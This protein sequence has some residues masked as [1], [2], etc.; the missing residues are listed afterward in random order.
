MLSTNKYAY[1][2]NFIPNGYATLNSKGVIVESNPMFAELLGM[3]YGTLPEGRFSSFLGREQ[4]GV[5]EAYCKS[6]A[7]SEV[8]LTCE[9][10]L[11]K[12]GGDKF[13]VML[14]GYR[15][16]VARNDYKIQVLISEIVMHKYVKEDMLIGEDEKRS[17]RVRN[18]QDNI[19]S[20]T[21]TLHDNASYEHA[22]SNDGHELIGIRALSHSLLLSQEKK[23]EKMTLTLRDD[24]GQAVA[25]LQMYNVGNMN[26]CLRDECSKARKGMRE[27][28]AVVEKLM[29]NIQGM[30]QDN[31]LADLGL[32][33]ALDALIQQKGNVGSEW[34]LDVK[35]NVNNL[36]KKV[37]VPLYHVACEAVDNIIRHA[38]AT[39]VSIKLNVDSGTAKL[40]IQDNG[41]GFDIGKAATGLGLVRMRERS[42]ASRG[43]IQVKTQAGDGTCISIQLPVTQPES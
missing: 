41:C 40:K 11:L 30:L 5:F 33:E 15:Q 12:Q 28:Q 9:L 27:S 31:T 16:D 2:H 10:P 14:T 6:I 21:G 3:K 22:A 39:R 43:S 4:R 29:K 35:E 8:P 23:H 34:I 18:A 37:Q 19:K 13:W 24:I 7:E 1:P 42:L 25:A 32:H 38:K 17:I 36:P 20:V 26:Y